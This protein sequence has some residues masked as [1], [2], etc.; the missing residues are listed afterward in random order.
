MFPLRPFMHIALIRFLPV[1]ILTTCLCADTSA[2]AQPPRVLEAIRSDDPIHIDGALLEPTWVIAP[3][4]DAFTQKTPNPGKPSRLRSEVKVLYDDEAVYIG[5]YLYDSDPDSILREYSQRD[6]NNNTDWFAVAFDPYRDGLNGFGFLLTASGIQNDVKI[7]VL[8]DDITWNAVWQSAYQI[9]DDG[10]IV[11]LKIPYSAIRFPKSEVQTWGIN[12][13]RSIRRYREESWWNPVDP[14]G[15]S[16]IAQSGRL[17]GIQGIKPPL[18]LALFPYV[19]GYLEKPSIPG[20]D[21]A[22][23]YN[24]GLDLKYGLSDAFT[25]DMT[26]VPDFGQVQFDDQ[27]LNLSPFEVQFNENRQFFTEGTELFNKGGVFYSRRVGD[28]PFYYSQVQHQLNEGDS[29]TQNLIESPLINATKISGRTRGNTGIGIFNAVEGRTYATIVDSIGNTREV[30]TNPLTNYNMLVIDQGLPHNSYVTLYNTNVLRS[31]SAYDANVSGTEVDLRDQKNRFAFQGAYTL[32][33]KYF[34]KPTDPEYGQR[35]KLKLAKISGNWQYGLTYYVE[36]DKYDPNDFGFLS[37]ANEKNL[38]GNFSYN[39]YDPFGNIL[40]MENYLDVTYSRLYKPDDFVSVVINGQNVTT[41]TGYLTSGLFLNLTPFGY[42]DYFE[43]RTPG[44]FYHQPASY[45]FGSFISPDYRKRFIVDIQATYAFTNER[46]RYSFNYVLG[47]RWRLSDKLSAFYTFDH[48]L[49]FNDRGFVSRDA[50]TIR[51]G[52]RDVMTMV[53]DLRVQYIF[54]E[55]MNLSFRG[56]H[57]WSY[58]EYDKFYTLNEAGNLDPSPYTGTDASERP[59]HDINFNALTI[60]LQYVWQFA[61]GSEVSI[62]F[63]NAVFQ[64]GRRIMS[65]YFEN[66]HALLQEP[67]F[68]SVSIKLLYYID[69]LM[70]RNWLSKS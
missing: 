62:V 27:V 49:V 66:T 29:V 19:S 48:R 6:E 56:R 14:T 2:L 1:I 67:Q 44:R 61:P 3:V 8:G 36:T 20:A 39:R 12:F 65:N 45:S 57:Y 21:F 33:Q 38:I 26:L 18:R 15:V 9:V 43:P 70:V 69:Y 37:S 42:N 4:A 35:Y 54:N 30:L 24:G 17:T 7:A 40:W 28:Q 22:T 31:G 50:D 64:Q 13:G 11:E 63:K 68:N 16:D 41:F 55:R 23:S 47:P 60:D 25:L 53:Q 52:R 10:W 51:F 46:G 32:S 34:T 59:K 5:A 58:A